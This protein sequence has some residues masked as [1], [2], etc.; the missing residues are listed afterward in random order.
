MA[1]INVCQVSNVT[2]IEGCW[3]R[4]YASVKVNG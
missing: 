3:E 1:V 4:F 2:P